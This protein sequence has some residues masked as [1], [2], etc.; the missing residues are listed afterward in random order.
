MTDLEIF[1]AALGLDKP[2]QVEEV[3][4]EADGKDKI[5]RLKIGYN[6]GSKFEYE[7]EKY[8]DSRFEIKDI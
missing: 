5:L 8:S 2:W 4:F 3:Y 7:G 1:T 6:K